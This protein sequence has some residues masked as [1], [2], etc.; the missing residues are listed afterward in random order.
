MSAS[1]SSDRAAGTLGSSESVP[2]LPD[3]LLSGLRIVFV[4]INPG[5]LSV[6]RGHYFARRSNRFWPAFSRSRLSEP[7]RAA[8]GRDQLTPEDDALLPNFAIGFTDVVKRPTAN[9]G[10]LRPEEFVDGVP[11]LL[12]ALE[13]CKPAVACFHGLTGYR[14]FARHA[15]RTTRS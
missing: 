10:E 8:L 9:A 14:P 13:T 2:T 7:I 15:L 1:A 11:R 12:A 5:L 4:G 6:R 3:Y